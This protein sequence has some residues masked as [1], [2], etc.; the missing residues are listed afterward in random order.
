MPA[1]RTLLRRAPIEGC[2]VVA[3]AMSA[4]NAR[5]ALSTVT[6]SKPSW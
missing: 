1:A 4:G 5:K 3:D 6:V 2:L